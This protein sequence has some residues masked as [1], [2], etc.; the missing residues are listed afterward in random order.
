MRIVGQ[1]EIRRSVDFAQAIAAMREAVIAQS[2]GDL[3]TPM[4]MH[5]DLSAGGGG[6]VHIKSSY[7]KGGRHFALKIAGSY[8]K[9]PYGSIVLVSGAVL[10]HDLAIYRGLALVALN[11][12]GD[13]SWSAH[14][15]RRTPR[16][17][18][19][20]RL[21]KDDRSHA[22]PTRLS[23]VSSAPSACSTAPRSELQTRPTV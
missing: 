23:R 19:E 18:S 16:L 22:T 6:E 3:D 13:P 10:R 14:R 15:V 12:H 17:S 1:D 2:R 9:G 21:N 5:L 4:P 7:R 20:T 8:A 11:D